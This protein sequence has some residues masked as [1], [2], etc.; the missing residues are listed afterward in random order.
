MLYVVRHGQTDWN[1]VHK[2]QGM[3]DIPLNNAGI[4]QANKIREMLKDI[5]FS[6]VFSSPLKRAKATAEIISDS[7]CD[8][9]IDQ[10]LMERNMGNYE[11]KESKYIDKELIWNYEINSTID[12]IED[13]KSI[14]KRISSFLDEYKDLYSNENVLVITHNNIYPAIDAYFNGIPDNNQVLRR[15]LENCEVVKFY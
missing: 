13:V 11:G 12:N 5:K 10:R 9:C 3:T 14:I 15:Y 6:K 2:V 7:K 1:A 4:E 8:V